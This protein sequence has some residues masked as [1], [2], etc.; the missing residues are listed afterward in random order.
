VWSV[1]KGLQ[2]MSAETCTF[3]ER[4]A[5]K[6]GYCQMHYK[7]TW[8][9]QRGEA[10]P[11]IHCGRCGCRTKLATVFEGYCYPCYVETQVV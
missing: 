7:R 4:S 3:C 5:S 8:R 10:D 2:T 6:A 9:V 1:W 11:A